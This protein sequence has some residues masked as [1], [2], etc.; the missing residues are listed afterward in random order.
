MFAANATPAVDEAKKELD[1]TYL[2][3]FRNYL[4]TSAMTWY[5]SLSE[6]VKRNWGT[7]KSE[8]PRQFKT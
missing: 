5:S 2:F 8:F 4:T 6:N 1:Q 7:L 3:L